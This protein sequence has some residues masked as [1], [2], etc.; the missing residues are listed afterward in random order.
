MQYG[1][2]LQ[3][4]PGGLDVVA[5]SALFLWYL[6]WM[7]G[8]DHTGSTY[9]ERRARLQELTLQGPSWQAPSHHEGDGAALLDA[10]AGQGLPGLVAKRIDSTY[11]PGERSNVWRYIAFS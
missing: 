8:H 5:I 9:R 6:L 7:D 4:D 11:Q 10:A 1:A 2:P 3:S